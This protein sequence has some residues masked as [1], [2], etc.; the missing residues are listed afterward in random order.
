MLY[1]RFLILIIQVRTAAT[2]LLRIHDELVALSVDF[3]YHLIL[4]L[5]TVGLRGAVPVACCVLPT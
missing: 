2:E 3:G 4:D 5:R 1:F